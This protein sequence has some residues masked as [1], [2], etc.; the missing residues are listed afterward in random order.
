MRISLLDLAAYSM[1]HA[2][3]LATP[4]QLS[5]GLFLAGDMPVVLFSAINLFM[6]F[7]PG[8]LIRIHHITVSP[9]ADSDPSKPI[10]FWRDRLKIKPS[11]FPNLFVDAFSQIFQIF[12]DF[13]NTSIAQL[14]NLQPGLRGVH[15]QHP[16]HRDLTTAGA[17]WGRHR[18]PAGTH[19]AMPGGC[20]KRAGVRAGGCSGHQ[21][22]HHGGCHNGNKRG[23]VTRKKGEAT[24]ENEEIGLF[25]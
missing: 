12:A 17:G 8:F 3:I 13:S 16:H 20:A 5:S 25:F 7:D 9:A 14:P 24:E 11:E 6:I 19:Q 15:A 1:R 22:T 10:S 18:N 4:P 2:S 23:V 21:A